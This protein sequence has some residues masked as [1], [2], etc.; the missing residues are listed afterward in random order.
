MLGDAGIGYM[1][2]RLADLSVPS[3]LLP[4]PKHSQ[5]QSVDSWLTDKVAAERL[6]REHIEVFFSRTMA[7]T[8]RLGRSLHSSGSW[9]RYPTPHALAAGI[10]DLEESAKTDLT[11]AMLWDAAKPEIQA[12]QLANVFQDQTKGLLLA[13]AGPDPEN[14]LYANGRWALSGNTRV[15]QCNWDWD[16]WLK[17]PPDSPRPNQSLAHYVVCS[18]LGRSTIRRI[19]P[20]T[21]FFLELFSQPRLLSDIEDLMKGVIAGG[22]TLDDHMQARLRTFTSGQLA[23]AWKAGLIAPAE[24]LKKATT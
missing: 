14:C 2:L 17:S 19:E 11:D 23:A 6:T 22:H 15:I 3:I 10:L 21:A 5:F 7:V 9:Q 20:T 24:L 13:L 16:K 18:Y 4:R 12:F 8:E 1:F